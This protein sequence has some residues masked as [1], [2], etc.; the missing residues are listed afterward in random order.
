VAATALA[1]F[2]GRRARRANRREVE[3]AVAL[4][5]VIVAVSEAEPR[6]L[7]R[8]PGEALPAGPFDPIA[9]PTLE[10]GLRRWVTEQTQLELGH[11]EQLYTFGDRDRDPRRAERDKRRAGEPR[12][13][14]IAY[15]AFVHE[16]AWR[17]D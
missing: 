8:V 4:D 5:A 12:T 2:A 13:L 3:L 14:S 15:L 6:V 9:D 16:H 1:R 10:M 7:V 11:V 17:Q